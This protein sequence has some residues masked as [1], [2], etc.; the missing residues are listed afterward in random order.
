MEVTD[1]LVGWGF[2]F[3]GMVFSALIWWRGVDTIDVPHT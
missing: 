3:V 2:V 1:E